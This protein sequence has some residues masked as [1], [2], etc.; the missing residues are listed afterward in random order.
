MFRR[1][2]Q[3]LFDCRKISVLRLQLSFWSTSTRPAALAAH[4]V[5]PMGRRGRGVGWGGGQSSCLGTLVRLRKPGTPGCN[6]QLPTSNF[7][8]QTDRELR[9]KLSQR[10]P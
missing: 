2:D 6:L 5:L 4:L 7:K 10:P 8:K 1:F 9:P 3:L